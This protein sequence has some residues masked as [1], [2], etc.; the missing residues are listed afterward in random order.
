MSSAHGGRCPLQ[1]KKGAW[2]LQWVVRSRRQSSRK[3]QVF[4]K[5]RRELLRCLA[6]SL[7]EGRLALIPCSGLASFPALPRL[8]LP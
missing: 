2:P 7:A 6:L 4:G 8:V 5:I 1:A 3:R